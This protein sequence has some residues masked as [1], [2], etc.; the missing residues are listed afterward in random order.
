MTRLARL[1]G[2]VLAAAMLLF[3]GIANA[4]NPPVM[5]DE[6][7][8]ALKGYDTVAYFSDGQPQP[9]RAEFSHRW[10]GATWLFT[11]AEHRDAFAAEPDGRTTLEVPLLPEGLAPGNPRK[12]AALAL[13][14]L[15]LDRRL[16]FHLHKHAQPAIGGVAI[17]L[18]NFSLRLRATVQ[19]AGNGDAGD[20][21]ENEDDNH[22]FDERESLFLRE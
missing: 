4:D 7:G 10:N 13:E 11:S 12:N 15:Q 20:D 5:I 8:L 3:I 6:A 18:A 16:L 2:T 17:I 9:G 14:T 21:A 1:I 22:H 19:V